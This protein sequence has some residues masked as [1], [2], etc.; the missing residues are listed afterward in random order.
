[1]VADRITHLSESL[2]RA[3][4]ARAMAT[5]PLWAETWDRFER[6]LL[7]RLLKCG[8]D[9]DMVRY[10]LQVGIEAARHVRAAIEHAGKTAKSL[11]KELDVLEGR[12]PASIA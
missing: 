12:K 8:P 2:N 4:D 3:A 7:E 1:M 10:R 9:D 11:E 5:T 6:E